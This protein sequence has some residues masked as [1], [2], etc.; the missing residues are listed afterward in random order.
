MIS[1]GGK[2]QSRGSGTGT[3]MAAILNRVVGEGPSEKVTFIK[4]LMEVKELA[5]RIW[6]EKHSRGSAASARPKGGSMSTMSE[7]G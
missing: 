1:V 7:V 3:G 4:E 6:R 2:T 5:M